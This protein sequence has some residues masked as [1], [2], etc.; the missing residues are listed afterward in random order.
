MY[1]VAGKWKNSGDGSGGSPYST[2]KYLAEIM[3]CRLSKLSSGNV[4][5]F[6]LAVDDNNKD[7]TLTIGWGQNAANG[8]G[9]SA[10][11]AHTVEP[12]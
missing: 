10:L 3:S 9:S 12:C 7:A 8:G 6:A 5:H 11:F 2:F 4:T 1:Y